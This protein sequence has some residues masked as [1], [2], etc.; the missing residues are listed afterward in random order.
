MEN[1]QM[2][3]RTVK[4]VLDVKISLET[5]SVGTVKFATFICNVWLNSIGSLFDWTSYIKQPC[6]L[7][8]LGHYYTY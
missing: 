7:L 8:V 6:W 2:F 5:S 4:P 3:E 1:E